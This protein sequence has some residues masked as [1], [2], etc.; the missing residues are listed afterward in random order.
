M[1][2]AGWIALAVAIAFV[3]N[4]VPAFMPSTWMVL[5]FF[6]IRYDLPL[7]PLSVAGTLASA[8]GRLALARGSDV[9]TRRFGRAQEGDLQYLGRFLD[10]HRQYVGGATFAYALSPLPTNQLFVAAGM[11]SVS[12]G[13]VIA[14]FLAARLLANT[15]LIWTT[16]RVFDSLGD[17]FRGAVAS[18]LA[19][20]LQAAGI[21]SIVL[22]YRLPWARWLRRW[23]DR[24]DGDGATA[25]PACR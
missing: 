18:W 6:F 12:L 14:G 20:A 3:I 8:A 23:A 7:V 17:I 25:T 13:W 1:S 21:V 4:L 9:L 2:D 24:D 10:R 19:V 15:A 22:L 16:D 11:T 5:A